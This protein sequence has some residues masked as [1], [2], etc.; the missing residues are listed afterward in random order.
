MAERRKLA[1]NS[2]GIRVLDKNCGFVLQG[3]G[4]SLDI[5]LHGILGNLALVE[6]ATQI[7]HG[8][9]RLL[10]AQGRCILTLDVDVGVGRGPHLGRNGIG[11]LQEGVVAFRRLFIVVG[12]LTAAKDTQQQNQADQLLSEDTKD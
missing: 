11:R 4:L 6:V 12:H 9:R 8:H 5:L 3:I 10:L 1:R 7:V 2:G